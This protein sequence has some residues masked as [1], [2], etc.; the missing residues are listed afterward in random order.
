MKK[1]TDTFFEQ[2]IEEYKNILSKGLM[3]SRSQKNWILRKRREYLAEPRK[4]TEVHVALLDELIPL[5]GYDWKEY[6]KDIKNPRKSFSERHKEV[7]KKLEKERK[8]NAR[9]KLWIKHIRTKFNRTSKGLSSNEITKMDQLIPLL[10]YDWRDTLIEVPTT[11]KSFD[12]HIAIITQSLHSNQPLSLPQKQWLRNKRK[13]YHNSPDEFDKTHEEILNSLNN[14]LGYDWKEYLV[15]AAKSKSFDKQF[16]EV[17]SKL[18]NNQKLNS[19]QKSWLARQK[20]Y[21]KGQHRLMTKK[22]I[23]ALDSLIPMLGYDWKI[24]KYERSQPIPFANHVDHIQKSLEANIDLTPKQVKWLNTQQRLFIKDSEKY[25]P[26]KIVLLDTLNK[27]LGFDW[28]EK[29]GNPIPKKH[30]SYYVKSIKKRITEGKKIT[31]T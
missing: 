6:Q 21:Y 28:K 17:L 19:R 2:R 3:L 26:K 9:D 20:E 27:S 7:Q 5:L 1:D 14:L 22:R 25:D 29:K 4:I 10:G 16:S 24:N 30:Y 11:I 31:N 15:K 23:N 18:S 13:Q 8:L 12:D